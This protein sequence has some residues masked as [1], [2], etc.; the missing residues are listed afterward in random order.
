MKLRPGIDVPA[1]ARE[2]GCTRAV[3]HKYL[4]GKSRGIDAL[5]LF[6]LCDALGVSPR[7]LARKQG[8]M[9]KETAL[10]PDQQRAMNVYGL[11]G[12]NRDLWIAQ[13]EEILRRQP[14]LIS[15]KEDPYRNKER[16]TEKAK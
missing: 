10:D 11:L 8:A 12:Q 9:A 13:G 16:R 3:L 6:D 2:V 7:W 5:L 15:T 14:S 4:N 1:L